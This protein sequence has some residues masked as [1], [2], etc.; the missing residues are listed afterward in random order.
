MKIKAETVTIAVLHG[1]KLRIDFSTKKLLFASRAWTI[2]LNW[3]D[4]EIHVFIEWNTNCTWK[5]SE[6][7][8]GRTERVWKRK[9]IERVWKGKKNGVRTV[10]RRLPSVEDQHRVYDGDSSL[11]ISF[12]RTF[13]IIKI[14]WESDMWYFFLGD[15]LHGGLPGWDHPRCPPCCSGACLWP[16]GADRGWRHGHNFTFS[17]SILKIKKDSNI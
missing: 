5:K 2:E 8:K 16:E 1:L 17:A 14:S 11:I 13:Y 9:R 15:V 3:K 12:A 7:Q 4:T 6:T 10:S